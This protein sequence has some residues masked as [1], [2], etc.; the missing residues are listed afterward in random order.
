[1]T[2]DPLHARRDDA[3]TLARLLDGTLD[4]ARFDHRDHL[5]VGFEILKRHEFFEAAHLLAD[6]LR[7]LAIRAGVPDKFNATVT[8]AYLSL[9]AERLH[10]A[11]YPDATAFIRANPTILDGN[12]LT[13]WFT[14]ERL[15]AAASREIPLLP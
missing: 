7:A 9:I 13:P 4:P 14:R 1:M 6:A 3:G 8:L 5:G 12:V 15:N 11:D 10:D 2:D